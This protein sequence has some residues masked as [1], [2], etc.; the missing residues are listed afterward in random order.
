MKYHTRTFS[1]Q[2]AIQTPMS[3]HLPLPSSASLPSHP[4]HYT[5]RCFCA[6]RSLRRPTCCAWY[7]S[8]NR[9]GTLPSDALTQLSCSGPSPSQRT[10]VDR[11]AVR[12]RQL[13]RRRAGHA[14]DGERPHIRPGA[15]DPP[16]AATMRSCAA[17][18][19]SRASRHRPSRDSPPS[20][21]VGC[22]NTAGSHAGR[23]KC[24]SNAVVPVAADTCTLGPVDLR[25]PSARPPVAGAPC[26]SPAWSPAAATARAIPPL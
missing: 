8:T 16:P 17:C 21:P 22:P 24:S 9:C 11:P 10:R 23:P 4:L 7:S 14:L 25:A 1:K 18:I 26:S 15:T 19:A 2:C 6:R 12:Q 3:H 20:G 5:P 13:R